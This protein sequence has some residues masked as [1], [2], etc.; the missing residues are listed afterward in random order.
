MTKL[1]LKFAI[2]QKLV[3]G[4]IERD[5]EIW[6]FRIGMEAAKLKQKYENIDVGFDG[7]NGEKRIPQKWKG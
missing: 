5:I 7:L 4:T 2:L 1:N 6:L 3:D